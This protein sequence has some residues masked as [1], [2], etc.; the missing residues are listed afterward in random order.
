MVWI[1][2]DYSLRNNGEMVSLSVISGKNNTV[3][4]FP[5][6]SA[7]AMASHN[8]HNIQLCRQGRDNIGGH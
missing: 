5:D 3:G 2:G 4:Y 1:S 6:N 8:N 7:A